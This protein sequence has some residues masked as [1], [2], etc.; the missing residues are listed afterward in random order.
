MRRAQAREWLRGHAPANE[1][2]RDPHD[3]SVFHNLD[4]EAELAVLQRLREWQRA[5]F[6]A[7]YAA[8]PGPRTSMAPGFRL[9]TP[10]RSRPRR[11]AS[12][13]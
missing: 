8:R 1:A 10:T 4:H 5:K 3:V 7:G 12:W 6:D 9:S 11:R 2:L 13:R